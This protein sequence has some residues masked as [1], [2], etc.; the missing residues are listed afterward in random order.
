MKILTKTLYLLRGCSG[1]G[2][3]SLSKELLKTSEDSVA[4]A[5]DDFF[6]DKE[7]NYNFDC[8]ELKKAHNY[9]QEMVIDQMF[10]GTEVIIVHN[11]L[12][13]NKELKPYLDMADSY[14]YKVVS[15]VVENRHGNESVHDVPND[16][17]ARQENNLLN[18][19]KLR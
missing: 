15:L 7:G 10:K 1:A 6:Y 8:K 11:T 19:I 2:K 5:A 14:K 13:S 12:T 3:T 18:S 17:L 16:T 9:C 4:I